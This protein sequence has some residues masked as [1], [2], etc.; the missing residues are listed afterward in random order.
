MDNRLQLG[1]DWALP[2][3]ALIGKRVA[4]LG[5]SGSGKTN[6][7]AVLAE[8]LLGAGV[9]VIVVDAMGQFAGLRQVAPVLVAG[10]EDS[11]DVPLTANTAGRLAEIV[12]ANRLS[13]VLD[14]SSLPAAQE[15]PTIAAFL[16]TYWDLVRRQNP[17]AGLSPWALIIDEAQHYIPESRQVATSDA[18]IDI[19]KRGRHRKLTLLLATQRVA[20]ARTDVLT[21]CNL[22]LSHRV[23]M[24][25]DVEFLGE[26]LPVSKKEIGTLMRGFPTGR[27]ILVG[28]ADVMDSSDDYRTVQI[29][30]SDVLRDAHAAPSPHAPMGQ[31]PANVLNDLRAALTEPTPESAADRQ[32]DQLHEMIRNLQQRLAQ[33][34]AQ[35]VT[36]PVIDESTIRELEA[37]AEMIRSAAESMTELG[38]AILTAL[39]QVLAAK[40]VQQPA[41][42]ATVY[43]AHPMARSTPP[44]TGDLPTGAAK[45]LRTLVNHH[46]AGFTLA[47]IGL[48]TGYSVSGGSFTGNWKLLRERGLVEGSTLFRA[49]EAALRLLG[50]QRQRPATL[51]ERVQMWRGALPSDGH[52]RVFDA[53]VNHHRYGISRTDLA[54]T[55]N[56]EAGAGRFGEILST[57]RNNNLMIVREGRLFANP[58]LY[59]EG[60]S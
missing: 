44:A 34:E 40:R 26:V 33:A 8:A 3:D 5:K 41:E 57:L 2:I 38:E 6:T 14:S 42:P 37:R 31:L 19:A 46:P 16:N 60:Q 12:F 28:D 10:A 25:A 35:V 51:A 55:T 56:Y 1:E 17:Q 45:V 24:G 21:Q 59:A 50:A 53:L 4:V 58:D 52:R 32:P 18:L 36:V 11:A 39:N 49:S 20:S 43:E 27:A 23:M 29:N 13:V 47:Q 7:L 48:L 9:P 30:R 54:E 15:V 22:I